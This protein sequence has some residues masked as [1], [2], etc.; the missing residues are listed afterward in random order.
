MA[1]GTSFGSIHSSNDLHL[2][3]QKVEVG[4]AEP[5]LNLIEIPG[6]DGAVDM[7]EQ[8][9][10]RVTYGT[11][12]ITWTFALYPGDSW[13]D[14]HRQVSNALNGR[15]FDIT[16]GTDPDYFYRG[17]VAVTKHNVDGLL[18]QIIVEALCQPY[19]LRQLPTTATQTLATSYK[20]MLLLN[21]RKPVVP[22]ITLTAPATIRWKGQTYALNAG[23]HKVLAIELQ[24]GENLLEVL[25]PGGSGRCTITYQEGAL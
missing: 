1:R 17:R 15:R 22:T 14:K 5:K 18:R 11:R 7:T 13:D 21:D 19:K 24:E 4:P 20:T 10:G 8:P 3:Q 23:E 25:A 2:I 16:L 9:A 6:A 12:K